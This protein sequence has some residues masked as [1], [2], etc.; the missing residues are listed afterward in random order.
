MSFGY[1]AQKPGLVLI[2]ARDL[3]AG[4]EVAFANYALSPTGI[5]AVGPVLGTATVANHRV[6]LRSEAVFLDPWHTRPV[7]KKGDL[8][9]LVVLFG[10]Q[11]GSSECI[12]LQID[13]PGFSE[14]FTV[15]P[16][17]PGY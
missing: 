8:P 15:T 6:T 1:E 2:R 9:E 11:T 7:D 3:K 10:M 17:V 5:S 4:A 14:N 16:S 13:G 12:G